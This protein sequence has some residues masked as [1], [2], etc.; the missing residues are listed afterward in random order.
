MSKLQQVIEGFR[1]QV[2]VVVPVEVDAD[3]AGGLDEVDPGGTLQPAVGRPSDPHADR[4]R[5]ILELM[6]LAMYADGV[7]GIRERELIVEFS[8]SRPWPSDTN[9]EL[10][11]DEAVARVR[12]ALDTASGKATL[13]SAIFDRLT[14]LSDQLLAL[15]HLDEMAASDGH[16][17]DAETALIAQLRDRLR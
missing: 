7:S 13:I 2:A 3:E 6:V 12:A 4:D 1:H 16:V 14:E 8:E 15:D 10:E 17:D 5:A 11:V 9:V